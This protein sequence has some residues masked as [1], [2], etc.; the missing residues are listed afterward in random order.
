MNHKRT[1]YS[2]LAG[3][4]TAVACTALFLGTAQAGDHPKPKPS[5]SSSTTSPPP[6]PTSPPPTTASPTPTPAGNWCSPGFWR[7][8]PGAVAETGVDMSQSYN[9]LFDPDLAGDP[10]LQEVLDSPQIYGGEAMNNVADFLSQAHPGVDFQ[11]DRVED[12]CPLSAD[13]AND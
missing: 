1:I 4:V 2:V 10:T 11:G 7:N 8:N 13:E 3:V 12:S 6:S 5:A 9:A